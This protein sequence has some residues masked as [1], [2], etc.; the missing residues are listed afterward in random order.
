MR[1]DVRVMPIAE[2]QPIPEVFPPATRD[3]EDVMRVQPALTRQAPV[4]INGAEPAQVVV[5]LE[6]GFTPLRP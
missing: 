3:R 1:V 5:A 4:S 2:R 6:D